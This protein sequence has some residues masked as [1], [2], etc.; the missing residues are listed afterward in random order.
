MIEGNER[1]NERA[2]EWSVSDNDIVINPTIDY[3]KVIATGERLSLKE[4]VDNPTL[5]STQVIRMPNFKSMPAR[6]PKS[7]DS[8]FSK[9]INHNQTFKLSS[10]ND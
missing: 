1:A 2:Q 6:S 7:I 5:T 4:K 9:N 8:H 3:S 10:S